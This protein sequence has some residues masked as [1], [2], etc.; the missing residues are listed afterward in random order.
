MEYNSIIIHYGE[1]ALKLGRRPYYEKL[2][3]KNLEKKLNRKLRRL[4]GRLVL[5]LEDSDW[6]ILSEKIGRAFGVVWYAPAIHVKK[7]IEELE[8][9]IIEALKQE[10]IRSFKIY[11]KRSDKTFPLKSIELAEKLGRNISNRLNLKVDLE[12]PEKKV[13]IE[14]T[15]DGF[16]LFFDKIAGLGGLPTGSSS[17][18]LSLLSGG[19]DSPVASWLMMKRGCYVDLLHIHSSLTH[20]EVLETKIGKIAKKLSDYSLGL[21]LYLASFKPFFLKSFELPPKMILVAFRAYMLRLA[22]RIARSKGYLGIVTGDSL[23]QVAS[24]T[25]ENLYAVNMFSQTP[26]YRP[27]IGMD[28]Q[29]IVDLAKKIGTYDL[30]IQEYRDCCAIIA[31]HPETRVKPQELRELWEKHNLEETVE[32]TLNNIAEYEF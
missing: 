20:D 22:D 18:V 2:L 32:E 9:K 27:L 15:E 26:T 3:K 13:Y 25:L 12:N 24:Q 8:E 10:D 7:D 21:T 30:S 6:R 14:V 1:I 29:E 5:K 31:R 23:G 11:V 19:I 17:K 28:K 16:Y 4:R